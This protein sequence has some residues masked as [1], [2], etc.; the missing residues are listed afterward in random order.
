M[1]AEAT[2]FVFRHSPYKG[3][4]FAVHL[5]IADSV[6]DQHDNQFWMSLGKLAAKSRLARP[7]VSACV[8]QMIADGWL[9]EVS[10]SVGSTV[11]YRFMFIPSEVVYESRWVSP[12]TTGGVT[13]DDR[14][15][16]STV[17][18]GV[19]VANPNPIEPKVE[20][21]KNE[22]NESFGVFWNEYPRQLNRNTARISYLKA[23]KLADADV[24]M[25][26][27]KW[28]KAKQWKGVEEKFIPVPSTWLN[29]RRW[30][31]APITFSMPSQKPSE[32]PKHESDALQRSGWIGEGKAFRGVP[33]DKYLEYRSTFHP[34]AHEWLD[35][36]YY[37]L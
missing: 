35:S 12:Q 3:A 7:T 6:N 8:Q 17:T 15:V 11:C 22:A 2:G 27:L 26:G 33:E 9:V 10:R 16:S 32:R 25:N 23:L 24:L 21:K 5:A 36:G 31:D 14:G 20:P 1:S 34:D 4:G 13:Q 37:D 29:Q 30:E 18:G 19:T 28:W